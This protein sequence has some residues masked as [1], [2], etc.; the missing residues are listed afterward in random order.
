M[1]IPKP[2]DRFKVFQLTGFKTVTL[3]RAY[4]K[5]VQKYE[6]MMQCGVTTGQIYQCTKSTNNLVFTLD[7]HLFDLFKIKYLHHLRVGFVKVLSK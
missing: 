2:N 7:G 1:W 3:G 4:G 6:K 5:N